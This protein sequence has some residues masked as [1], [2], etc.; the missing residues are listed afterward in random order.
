MGRISLKFGIKILAI[1]SFVL[2]LGF[3]IL[4]NSTKAQCANGGESCAL[5]P[6]CSGWECV[7][8]FVGNKCM[9]PL[10]TS[11]STTDDCY[12]I[13]PTSDENYVMG[14]VNGQCC[15]RYW[16]PCSGNNSGRPPQAPIVAMTRAVL[17]LFIVRTMSNAPLIV[18]KNRMATAL[19]G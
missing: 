8:G 12:P 3:F 1:F 19:I 16:Y 2:V 15:G 4:P 11:C 17:V 9:K 6:C 13:P 18:L 10:G 5:I 7:G 14:C